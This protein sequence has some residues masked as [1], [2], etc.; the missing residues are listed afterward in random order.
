MRDR[1]GTLYQTVKPTGM[2]SLTYPII[3]LLRRSSFV[4]FTFFFFGFPALQIQ[5]LTFFNVIY[6]IY[7]NCIPRYEGTLIRKIDIFNESCF[8]IVCYHMIVFSN[9]YWFSWLK[10]KWQIPIIGISLV[11][12]ILI[13]IV[14][15]TSIILIQN[16][17]SLKHR[18][19]LRKL[20]SKR[21]K[22]ITERN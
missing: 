7:I 14:V 19:R 20:R 15:S 3:F 18:L 8:L 10:E 12:C 1:I 9:L 5:I 13:V 6:I 21:D 11:I 17:K 2:K 16:I 22:F 4:A